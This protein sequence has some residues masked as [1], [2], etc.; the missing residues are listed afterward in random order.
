MAQFIAYNPEAEV[1]GEAILS[2]VN[3]I[4]A[5]KDIR[6]KI[7]QKHGINPEKGKWYKQQLWLD[8]MK[9]IH[10]KIGKYNLLVIGKAIIK[11]AIFPPINNLEEALNLLD[12]AYHMNHRINGQILYNPETNE[13]YEGIGNYKLVEFDEENRKAVMV[14]DNPYPDDFDKG[15]IISLVRRYKPQDSLVLEEVIIDESK[16]TRSE[17]KD[18]TTYLI[19]W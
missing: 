4:P 8:A 11:N 18:S 13:L 5:G 7:L 14:C 1:S 15:I 12:V 9:E 6:L 10:D 2:V 19:H 16:G 17:G 3:A